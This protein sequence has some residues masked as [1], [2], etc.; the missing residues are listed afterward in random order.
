MFGHEN[1]PESQADRRADRRMFLIVLGFTFLSWIILSTSDP[2]F[3]GNVSLDAEGLRP[4]MSE[5]SSHLAILPAIAI[6]PVL[7]NLLPVSL[8]NWRQR[9]LPYAFGFLLFS[10]IHVLLME[11]FRLFSFPFILGQ[12]YETGLWGSK[13]WVYELRKDFYTYLLLV[14]A[15]RAMRH[16]EQLQ[17]EAR[18]IK[19]EA[20][21]SGRLELKSGGRH[22]FLNAKDIL[23]AKAVSNYVEVHTQDG[24]HL[25]RMTL[26]ALEGLLKEAGDAH[27]R[28]HR[29]YLAKR[30]FIREIVPTGDG[31]AVAKLSNKT[32]LPISRKYR[33]QFDKN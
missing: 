31:A 22:V 27:I 12:A 25:I 33:A 19:H 5:L 7:L 29:S 16:I 3:K 11:I 32:D 6:I 21:Q 20:R 13:L 17:L 2:L 28:T 4:W 14:P 30:D 18:N 15:F 24:H 9:L 26:T 23:W 8:G 1:N 10:V